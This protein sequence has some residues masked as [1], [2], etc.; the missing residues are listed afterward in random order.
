MNIYRFLSL[1]ISSFRSQKVSGNEFYFIIDIYQY[2]RQNWLTSMGFCSRV[3]L[4]S[5]L[6]S[7]LTLQEAHNGHFSTL[8]MSSTLRTGNHS[9]P[10]QPDSAHS[11]DDDRTHH[12]ARHVPLGG[13]RRQLSHHPALFRHG[14]PVGP[15]VLGLLPAPGV[16]SG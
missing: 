10:M 3:E 5:P 2:L 7:T 9:A 4:L 16:L 8:A 13:Q 11:P 1:S 14:P 6:T 12:H 15:S